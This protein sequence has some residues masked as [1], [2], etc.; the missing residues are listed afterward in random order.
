MKNQVN[1]KII[2]FFNFKELFAIF[3]NDKIFYKLKSNKKNQL[4]WYLIILVIL[5]E[6]SLFGV[7][8]KFLI[9]FIFLIL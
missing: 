6:K 4:L 3:T 9:D 8:L 1:L 5:S 2:N 7:G